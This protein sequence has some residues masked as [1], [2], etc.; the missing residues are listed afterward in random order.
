M[1]IYN[2]AKAQGENKMKLKELALVICLANKIEVR[3][4]SSSFSILFKNDD[5]L[6]NHI[7]KEKAFG[8]REVI[9]VSLNSPHSSKFEIVIN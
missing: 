8:E 9:Y 7:R 4:L 5:E 3:T 6:W 2:Q 1:I